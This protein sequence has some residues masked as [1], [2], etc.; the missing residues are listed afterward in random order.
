ME[1]V[2]HHYVPK[3]YLRNF[4]NNDK[5]IGMFINRNKRY[6]KHASIK[7]QACKEYLYGKEQTIEDA[8]M[9]IENKASVIIKNIINSSKLPQK[10]TEDYHFLLMYILLQEAKVGVSI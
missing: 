3:F 7:E 1:K 8:L 2:R 6:I 10:E 5:S 4:S 9:N